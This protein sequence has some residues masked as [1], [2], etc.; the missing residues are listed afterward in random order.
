VAES[1]AGERRYLL[2]DGLRSIRQA[3]DEYGQVVAY[4]EFDPYGVPVQ[5]GGEPYGYTAEWWESAT[6]L[7]YLRARYYVRGRDSF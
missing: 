6:E 5:G 1:R 3:V 2:S 4:H 7:L